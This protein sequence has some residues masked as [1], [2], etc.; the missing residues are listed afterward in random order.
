MFSFSGATV[1]G[2]HTRLRIADDRGGTVALFIAAEDSVSALLSNDILRV[3]H[4][5]LSLS[6]NTAGDSALGLY[7]VTFFLLFWRIGA[8]PNPTKTGLLLPSI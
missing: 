3:L 1:S 2:V 5:I 6:I 8:Q 4:F 7:T